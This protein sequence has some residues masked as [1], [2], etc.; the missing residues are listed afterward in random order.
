M[1]V[2]ALLIALQSVGINLSILMAGSA[3][4]LVGIGFGL[5]N[6]FNDFSSGIFI[7]L[8]GTI[9]VGDVIDANGIVGEVKEIRLRTTKILTRDDTI[10]IVPN[11]KFIAEP[12]LNWS[13]NDLNTRFSIAIGVAYGSDVQLVKRCLLQV[14]NENEMISDSPIPFVRFA[15]FG[16][17]SLDFELLF[18][19]TNI[20]QVKN[21]QSE[22]RFEIDKVFRENKV[23]IPFPQ[24]DIHIK[25]PS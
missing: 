18:W 19:T 5:Q 25:N 7:L 20:F 10:L 24:R 12:V 15:D 1:W 8:E 2:I 9:S 13:E 22:L 3:A 11:H 4:L 14:A 17:S 16:E 6:I 21:I 23:Q